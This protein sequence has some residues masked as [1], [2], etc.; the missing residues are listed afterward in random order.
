MKVKKGQNKKGQNEKKDFNDLLIPILVVLVIIPLTVYFQVYQ[1]GLAKYDWY[2]VDDTVYDFYIVARQTILYIISGVML[3][4]LAFYRILYRDKWRPV[5]VLWPLGVLAVWTIISACLAR[6]KTLVLRGGEGS[7]ES[8]FVSLCYLVILIYV[9]QMVR[10]EQDFQMIR[11]AI[12]VLA[13]VFV[14]V[15]GAQI[16]GKDLLD[17]DWIQR[18]LMPSELESEF[19]GNLGNTF[20]DGYVFLTLFNPNY[21]AQVLT[22]L[23]TFMAYMAAV[24]SEKK[25]ML[26][27]YVISGLL[28]VLLFFTYSRTGLFVAIIG[29]VTATLL[30][31]ANKKIALVASGIAATMIG[32][33]FA[34]DVM[35]GG[36]MQSRLID[37]RIN[38]PIEAMVTDK[39]GVHIN[40]KGQETLI[41]LELAQKEKVI[42]DGEGQL[43]IENYEDEE[44]LV[45]SLD[46]NTWRFVKDGEAYYYINDFGKPDSLTESPRISLFGLEHLASGRGYI[47]ARAIPAIVKSPIWGYGPDNFVMAYPQNDYVGKYYYSKDS[48]MVIDKAHNGYLQMMV[49]N[50]IPALVLCIV[51]VVLWTKRE[52]REK[53]DT[54]CLSNQIGRAAFLA[55]VV[56]LISLLTNDTTIFTMPSVVIFVGL[57]M[58]SWKTDVL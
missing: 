36:R 27:Y 43:A 3:A 57:T 41:N 4:I 28:F 7:G 8:V 52:V 10:T 19:V 1:S 56:Y 46:G 25:R 23:L 17:F 39:Q 2:A 12:F 13:A 42:F 37:Q 11:N 54:C 29:F 22:M 32:V 14:V 35:L 20:S 6:E 33:L 58:A 5:K 45:V 15:G 44:V 21:A 31:R 55:V 53:R 49:Q 47:W 38:M 16:V 50:G 9:Y 18:L 24:Q 48:N 30:A 34:S 51:F 40:Y 26:S